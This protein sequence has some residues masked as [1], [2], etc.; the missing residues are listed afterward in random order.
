MNESDVFKNP[1]K[2]LDNFYDLWNRVY[3]LMKY[4]RIGSIIGLP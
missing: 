4:E 2:F 3:M 1:F